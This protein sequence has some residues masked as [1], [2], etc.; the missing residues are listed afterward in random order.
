MGK[1]KYIFMAGLIFGAGVLFASTWEVPENVSA[2]SSSDTGTTKTVGTTGLPSFADIVKKG[3]PAVVNISTTKIVKNGTPE[4]H[5]FGG[6]DPFRDFFGDDFFD[7]FFNQPPNREYKSQSL[8]SGFVIDREGYILTNN[9]VVENADEIIVRFSNEKEYEAKIIG[10][11]PKTDVALIKIEDSN[12]LPVVALGDS[13]ALQVGEWVIAIGNPFGVGQTVTAGIVSAKGREIGAGPY[14]DFIQTDA[15]INPGNSGGP[16]FNVK[17]EVVGINTAIFSPSGGNVGIG[18]AIPVNMV[19]NML[20]QLKNEGTITRGWLGVVIQPITKGLAEAFGLDSE[21]G[22][23]VADVVDGSPAD[24]AGIKKGDVITHFDGKKISK[25]RDLPS[26]V[27]STPVGS[28]VRVG[29]VR[30]GKEKKLSAKIEKLKEDEVSAEEAGSAED[31]LGISV[32]EVTPELARRLDLEV[33]RGV[34]VTNIERGSA[35]DE[36]GLRRGDII[37]EINTRRIDDMTGYRRA[38]KGIDKGDTA[39][40]L[41]LRG[42]N[43]FFATVMRDK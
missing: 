27:A 42:G 4:G 34:L 41:I 36:G 16:L 38:I 10:R 21:D 14:D 35:A 2:L 22:A 5:P 9:H 32:Q 24:K 1:M 39:L 11:D 19:K 40:F 28:K 20:A 7:R 29:V 23:L 31:L 8:G 6:G 18:F 33:T 25:M 30:G 43:T 26:V 3:K 37:M 13:D 17:G 12:N 15:S